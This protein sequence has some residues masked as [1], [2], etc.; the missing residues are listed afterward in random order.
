MTP[1][2]LE[3]IKSF[4][5][6]T[7]LLSSM[8]PGHHWWWVCV[9]ECIYEWMNTKIRFLIIFLSIFL[10]GSYWSWVAGLVVRLLV[11]SC[12]EFSEPVLH[13]VLCVSQSWDGTM[14][15]ELKEAWLA[16]SEP[17]LDRLIQRCSFI[18][19]CSEGFHSQ[20]CKVRNCH[21]IP[22]GW[23]FTYCARTKSLQG[24]I[25]GC[26]QPPCWVLT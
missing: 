4:I 7:P 14:A 12:S 25:G 8:L 9:Y 21:P 13:L 20:D 10:H 17:L 15:S 6:F 11:C 26:S 16:C 2:S 3:T 19:Q 5:L 24:L 18:P 1:L 22:S 23:W